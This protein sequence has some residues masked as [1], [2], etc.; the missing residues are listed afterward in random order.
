MQTSGYSYDALHVDEWCESTDTTPH[1]DW[2]SSAKSA[3]LFL[4]MLTLWN[5]YNSS[6][7][8]VDLL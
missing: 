6:V 1:V 2:L 8:T 5:T 4:E 7:S 3:D